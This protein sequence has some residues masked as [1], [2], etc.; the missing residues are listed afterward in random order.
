MNPATLSF[1]D[2]VVVDRLHYSMVVALPAVMEVYAAHGYQ[3]VTVTEGNDTINR[4]HFSYHK[5]IPLRALDFRTWADDKG[6]Q[7]DMA[8]KA[9]IAVDLRRKLGK[10]YDVVYGRWNLHVEFD[11]K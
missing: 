6:T 7:M 9:A 3:N 10:Q 5:T 8:Q 11:P 4:Q 1:K 2:G